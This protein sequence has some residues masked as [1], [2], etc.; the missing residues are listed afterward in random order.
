VFHLHYGNDLRGLAHRLGERLIAPGGDPLAPAVV[1]IPQAG[2]RRWLEIELAEAFG[3]VAN[4]DFRLPAEFVWEVLRANRPDLPIRS[5]FD[6]DILR[7]RLMPL[8]ADLAREPVGAAVARYLAGGDEALK[9]LQLAR[10]LAAALERYQAYRRELLDDW[11]RGDDAGDWQAEIWRRLVRGSDEP[12]RA[13]LIGDFLVRHAGGRAAPLGLPMRL[14]VFGCLNVS[15]DVLRVLGTLADYCEV[16]FHL[17]SPCREYW[18]DLRSVRERLRAGASPLETSEQ[19]L[20]ASWGRVGREF[21]DQVFSYDE[22]QP[23]D[24]T[25]VL[26]E[27]SRRNLLGRVQAD[28]LDLRTPAAAER[29]CSAAHDD[30]SLR[31]HA[32]HSPLREVQVLHDHLL[33]AFARDPT[34]K[35]RDI[36]V[37]MPDVARYAP[38]IDAVFGALP[39]GDPRR[40]P[41]TVADRSAQDEHPIVEVFLKLLGLPTSRWTANELLDLVSV[42]AVMR[43][44]GLDEDALADLAHW[45]EL[46][47]V[48][49]GLDASTR[50]AFAAGD[51][52]AF[53]WAE[54]IER[55]LLGYAGGDDRDVAGIAPVAAVE[56]HA[57]TALGQALLAL[58]ELE[59]L[60]A[61]QRSPRRAEEWRSAYQ[62]TLDALLPAD[63]SDRDERR[64]VQ[65]VRSA[66]TALADD[67]HAGGCDE[68]LDWQTVRAFLAERL[69]EADVHQRFL[70]GGVSFCGMVPLR[71]IPFRLIAVL[72]LDDE[73]FPRREPAGGINRLEQAL[74]NA[75][76]LGDRSVR[77]DDRYLFL[78]ILTSAEDGLHLSYVGRDA[79]TGDLREP[80]ALVAELLDVLERD[81]VADARR[82]LVADHPLQPFARVA[83]D[84]SRAGVFTYRHEWRAAAAAERAGAPQAFVTAELA[85]AAQETPRRVALDRLIDFWRNPARGFLRDALHLDLYADDET[86]DDDDP[87]DLGDLGNAILSRALVETALDDG[88]PPPLQVDAPLRM[89]YGLPV[90]RAGVEAYRRALRSAL[91]TIAGIDAWRREGQALPPVSF[92][93]TLDGR[94]VECTLRQ[95]YAQG[96]LHWTPGAARGH[97]WLRPWIEYLALAAWDRRH[98]AGFADIAACTLIATGD[99]GVETARLSGLVGEHA[100]AILADLLH[101]W[102]EGRRSPLAFFPKA[103]WAYVKTLADSGDEERAL[104]AAHTE[105]DGGERGY[106]ERRNPW[107]A[108]AW[109]DREPFADPRW[110]AAFQA[111]AQRMFGPL[112]ALARGVAP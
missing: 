52:R 9:R 96:L 109:R 49:W 82:S 68:A 103:A 66:L 24:E 101:G 32:C 90:G 105:Y 95:T 27:P 112:V 84:G 79:R 38:A 59:R 71:A 19:P 43:G 108:L 53:T 25:A 55:L 100:R 93:L 54:G 11:E 23:A 94:I 3:I 72:G 76:K 47:G 39:A 44:L 92:E 57:A 110:L 104:R 56:G 80:S 2:L 61:A 14:G 22:V 8:L 83:F 91:P 81:Y 63:L 5:A 17:P 10:E 73:T 20:L 33:A 15:P 50:A 86:I 77:D 85:P 99:G 65:L 46:A 34:L 16:D 40:I 35:P 12:H 78:Q 97:L 60:A 70:S 111:Q 45:L 87:L 74:R 51:Y 48:R 106:G 18:G 75:R 89:R 67:A 21:F 6:R 1:L 102:D 37:M 7:W 42:P 4:V 107:I 36:A 30:V 98:A 64:A 31:V 62:R 28:I 58:R 69:A 88:T 13:R 29:A 41:Y 26:R